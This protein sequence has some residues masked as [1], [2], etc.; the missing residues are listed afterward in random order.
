MTLTPEL[1]AICLACEAKRVRA[2][3]ERIAANENVVPRLRE[4]ARRALEEA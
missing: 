2:Q 3:L 4:D 1:V